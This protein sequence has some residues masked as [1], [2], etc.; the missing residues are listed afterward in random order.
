M[1]DNNQPRAVPS[2]SRFFC[3]KKFDRTSK[4]RLYA[5][6]PF[7]SMNSSLG[8]LKRSGPLLPENPDHYRD[9]KDPCPVFDGVQ[10]HVFG[11]GGSSLLEE[12][13][14]IHVTAPSIEG[15][16]TKQDFLELQGVEGMHIAAPGV[17]FEDGV[18]HMFVQRDFMALGGTV[19]HLVSSDGH[20]FALYDTP[21]RSIPDSPEAGLYDPHPVR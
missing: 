9:T 8:F 3:G 21:L 13:K 4:K 7:S 19:D 20:H 16:W 10:W 5:S 12:W 2:G 18:F 17:V 1:G 11:S 14:L 15:P 6:T